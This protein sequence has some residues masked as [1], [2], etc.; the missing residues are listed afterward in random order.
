MVRL[1]ALSA[2]LSLSLG[3]FPV[4]IYVRGRVDP[5]TIVQVFV[6]VKY[7]VPAG[8]LPQQPVIMAQALDVCRLSYRIVTGSTAIFNFI[9]RK[10]N[11]SGLKYVA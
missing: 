4:L 3:R 8:D 9:R 6:R 2:G 1:S 7:A 10:R 5:R 11:V